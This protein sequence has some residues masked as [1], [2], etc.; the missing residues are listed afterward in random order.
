MIIPNYCSN[1][2]SIIN[3]RFDK[4]D[5]YSFRLIDYYKSV[6]LG[7]N[8]YN[9]INLKQFDSTIYR[10][11]YDYRFRAFF[12]SVISKFVFEDII[13]LVDKYYEKSIMDFKSTIWI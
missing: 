9:S 5:Y 2:R 6:V 8:N 12:Q 13:V 7:S 3:Y 4:S 1:Y 10:Y 11:L